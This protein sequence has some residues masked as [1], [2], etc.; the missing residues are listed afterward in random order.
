MATRIVVSGDQAK[1]LL[2]P[3]NG[4]GGFQSLLRRLQKTMEVQVI[5]SVNDEDFKR[6]SGYMDLYGSGGYQD[7]IIRLIRGESGV[8]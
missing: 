5:L 6:L 7:R 8:S 3:V 4:Q 2:K 1:E